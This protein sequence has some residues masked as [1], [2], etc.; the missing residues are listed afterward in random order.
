MSSTEAEYIA[1]SQCA[2][3][4]CWFHNLLIEIKINGCKNFAIPLYEN[5]QS[6]I[7]VGKSYEQVQ[8]KVRDGTVHV[9]YIPSTE[10]I[11]YLLNK[12]LGKVLFEKFKEMFG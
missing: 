12:P 10:Q 5:N 7:R 2:T 11:A 9:L 8:E 1:L 4:A 3:E 6:A